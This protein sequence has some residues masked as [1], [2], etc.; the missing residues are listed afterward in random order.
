M[1][2][3]FPL[4]IFSLVSIPRSTSKV[5]VKSA[6]LMLNFDHASTLKEKEIE[7][8]DKTSPAT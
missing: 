4:A 3:D 7:S 6:L 1:L 2:P 5:S 8:L